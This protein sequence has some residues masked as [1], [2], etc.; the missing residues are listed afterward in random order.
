[1]KATM[2]ERFRT[3]TTG[4]K[5]QVLARQ[6]LNFINLGNGRTGAEKGKRTDLVMAIQIAHQIKAEEEPRSQLGDFVVVTNSRPF[7]GRTGW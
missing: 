2:V 7:D 1:M 4:I 5:S 3:Q 6:F